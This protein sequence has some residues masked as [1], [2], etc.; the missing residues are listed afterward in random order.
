M[1]DFLD[2]VTN[3]N[4]EHMYPSQRCYVCDPLTPGVESVKGQVVEHENDRSDVA[5]VSVSIPLSK[6]KC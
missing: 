6:F 2:S 3:T 5:Q 1:E 4:L